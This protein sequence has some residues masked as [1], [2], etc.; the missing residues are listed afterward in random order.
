LCNNLYHKLAA[1]IGEKLEELK[2]ETILIYELR[3]VSGHIDHIAVSLVSM[4][5]FYKLAFIKT[6]LQY[7]SKEAYT[8]FMKD[9]YIYFPPG[10]KRSEADK[11]I[12]YADVW[13][14]RVKA[15]QQHKSQQ[16]DVAFILNIQQHL[17]KE[18]YFLVVK[19]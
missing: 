9:Y 16:K 19:K 14:T 3:G 10:L 12:D 13:E 7:C 15:M 2:P 5:L 18:D 17:P 1:K 11:I 6:V 8:K 4:F